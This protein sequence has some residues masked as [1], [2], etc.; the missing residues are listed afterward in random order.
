M[1][2]RKIFEGLKPVYFITFILTGLMVIFAEAC[3]DS[4]QGPPLD[5]PLNLKMVINNDDP[6]T[7]DTSLRVNIEGV[8]VHWMQISSDST[9]HGVRWV[10]FDTLVF[11][12]APRVEMDFYVYGRFATAGG[13]TTGVLKDEIKLDF[14]SHIQEVTVCAP[15]RGLVAGDVVEF[16]MDCGED[17][18]AYV[19]FGSIRLKYYLDY[20]GLGNFSRQLEIP[21]GIQDSAA[22]TTGYF[23]D[24]VGNVAEPIQA[25]RVIS[26]IGSE[27]TPELI[28]VL[29]V[30]TLLGE[31]IW[32]H[33]GYCFISDYHG[34]RI[35]DFTDLNF[36]YVSG[37]IPLGDWTAGLISDGVR[38]YTTYEQAVAVIEIDPPDLPELKGWTIVQ[39]KARDI[40]IDSDYAYVSCIS[41][42]I[43]IF[44]IYEHDEPVFIRN[45]PLT[46]YGEYICKNDTLLYVGGEAQVS[47][48]N[49]RDPFNPETVSTFNV[50]GNPVDIAYFE[51]Y[52]YLATRLRGMLVYNVEDPRAPF[53]IAEH[54]QFNYPSSLALNPPFLYIGAWNEIHVVN[55]T[56][57]DVLDE[58]ASIPVEGQINGIFIKGRFLYATG[59]DRVFAI[60]LYQI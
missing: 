4:H 29:E 38:L 42:G 59:R 46:G 49:I 60:D 6:A 30:D 52:L 43:N 41:T 15:D 5:Y 9:L 18:N 53:Q 55:A 7:G 13:G 11:I 3:E 34:V 20:N 25:E 26:I 12:E 58:V 50:E 45:H 16:V 39:G 1:K 21:V 2:W 44:E 48:V 10:E 27:I 56:H 19:S 35:I 28:T 32:H 24:A 51:D 40:V 14:S 54:H 57:T 17:G 8:N 31:D 23:T 22:V 47:I 33:G 37:F 36:P